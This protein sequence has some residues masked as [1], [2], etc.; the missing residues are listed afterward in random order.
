MTR[1]VIVSDRSEE[2]ITQESQPRAMKEG[3]YLR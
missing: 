3:D 1:D 2:A